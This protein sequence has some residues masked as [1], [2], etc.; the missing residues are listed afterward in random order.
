MLHKKEIFINP[1]TLTELEAYANADNKLFIQIKE[2][3][4][5]VPAYIAIT[6]DTAKELVRTI[7][8]EIKFL[9]DE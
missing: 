9:K 3:D 8:K 6:K 5:D 2:N 1:E 4:V 7:Q